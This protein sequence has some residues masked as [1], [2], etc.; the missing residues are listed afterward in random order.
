VRSIAAHEQGLVIERGTGRTFI[1]WAKVRSLTAGTAEVIS[2]PTGK[3]SLASSFFELHCEGE[4]PIKLSP[5]AAAR[6]ASLT[7]AIVER[8]NLEWFQ[9]EFR[10]RRLPPMAVRPEVAANL[11]SSLQA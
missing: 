6:C 8:A 9:P 11:R 7:S 10:G 4:P 3:T 2:P 1:A 5:R